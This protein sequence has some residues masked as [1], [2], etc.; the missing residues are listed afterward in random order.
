MN[1]FILN[2]KSISWLFIHYI[3]S[4]LLTNVLITFR[5]YYSCL[6]FLIP[7]GPASGGEEGF[8]PSAAT[9]VTNSRDFLESDAV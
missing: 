1:E 2:R 6:Q 5:Y 7:T 9:K 8:I 4:I 3:N